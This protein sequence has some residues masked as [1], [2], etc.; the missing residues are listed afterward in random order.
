[1]I[2]IDGRELAELMTDHGVAASVE[3]RYEIKRIDSDYF[4]ADVITN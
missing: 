4:S 2:S 3:V 1:V